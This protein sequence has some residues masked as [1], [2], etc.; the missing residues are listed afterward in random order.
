MTSSNKKL[1]KETQLFIHLLKKGLSSKEAL[2]KMTYGY[3]DP[4]TGE[5][6]VIT[7][8]LTKRFFCDYLDCCD[9]P[10]QAFSEFLNSIVSEECFEMIGNLQATEPWVVREKAMVSV[11]RCCQVMRDNQYINGFTEEIDKIREEEK[12]DGAE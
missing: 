6:I 9:Y 3:E 11:L 12:S 8:A 7:G 5:Y 1:D 10:G 4:D 2:K